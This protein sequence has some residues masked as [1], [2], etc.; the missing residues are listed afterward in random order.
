MTEKIYCSQCH[1]SVYV[2]AI[3]TSNSKQRFGNDK[4][5]LHCQAKGKFLPK[6]QK[7]NHCT[8][9]LPESVDKLLNGVWSV[10]R[11]YYGRKK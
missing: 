3:T 9:L 8:D 10:N 5:C 7:I 1:N 11:Y 6:N 4:I 2:S